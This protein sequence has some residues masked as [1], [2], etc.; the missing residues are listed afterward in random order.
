MTPKTDAGKLL[1]IP[2]ALLTIPVTVSFLSYTGSIL[3]GLTEILM[4]FI[5]K[6]FKKHKP[7]KYKSIKE[8]FYLFIFMLLIIFI[9]IAKVSKY[10]FFTS[11][12]DALYFF[13]VTY[14][15]IGFGDITDPAD[16]EEFYGVELMLGLSV[17]SSLVDSFLGLTSK[18]ELRCGTR[19]NFLCCTYNE[20]DINI[21]PGADVKE[22][23]EINENELSQ[24]NDVIDIR[25]DRP[26]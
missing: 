17:V 12:L 13:V 5:H 3:V 11:Y 10:S 6:R 1:L 19:Q 14:T 24:E 21:D 4:I 15:T 8:T 23:S 26:A 25:E 22:E 9:A 16:V 18:F 2:Y 7:L 20:D